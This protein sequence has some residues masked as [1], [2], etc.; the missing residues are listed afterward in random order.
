MAF[1]RHSRINENRLLHNHEGRGITLSEACRTASHYN[2]PSGSRSG[3]IRPFISRREAAV[4]VNQAGEL[5]RQISDLLSNGEKMSR[6]RASVRSLQRPRAAETVVDDI[7]N[8]LN[9][10]ERQRK[11]TKGE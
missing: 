5:Y 2:F 3:E 1:R 10:L 11:P 6:M 8:V 9:E 7:L 4:V